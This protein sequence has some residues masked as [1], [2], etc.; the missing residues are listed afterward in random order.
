MLKVMTAHVFP[1]IPI[2]MFDW[3]AWFD[4]CEEGP[5]GTGRTEDDAVADLLSTQGLTRDLKCRY[6]GNLA[7]TVLGCGVGG[8]PIGEDA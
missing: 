1:P 3:A 8:C 2:R 5:T 7:A 4:G 6:C